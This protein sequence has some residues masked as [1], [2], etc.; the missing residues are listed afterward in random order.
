[1]IQGNERLQKAVRQVAAKGEPVALIGAIGS[2][3]STVIESLALNEGVQSLLSLR[4]TQVKGS[5]S[6]IN[7]VITDFSEIPE[8][9]LIVTAKLRSRTAIDLVDD[10]VLLGKII[11]SAF[12]KTQSGNEEDYR[13]NLA[14]QLERELEHPA[15]DT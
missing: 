15:N 7:I 12:K 6:Q 14:K 3:K 11:Y 10:N 1:M 13:K 4:E 5:V 8:D 9:C 2:G